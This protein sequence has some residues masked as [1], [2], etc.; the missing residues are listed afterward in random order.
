VD[1]RLDIMDLA[2]RYA[3]AMDGGDP[4]AYESVFIPDAVHD[5]GQGRMYGRD[6]INAME[7]AFPSDSAFPGSK[8]LVSQFIIE[9]NTKRANVRMYVARFTSVEHTEAI[10]VA[11]MGFYTDTVVKVDDIWYFEQK[12]AHYPD[13]L[14]LQ[15]FGQEEAPG[16]RAPQT[17]FYDQVGLVLP[18]LNTEEDY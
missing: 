16:V 5:P 14:R 13:E 12:K 2:A 11:W 9:G 10:D 7:R 18:K 17:A 15:Q 1:D 6:A 4:E 8:H 3:W